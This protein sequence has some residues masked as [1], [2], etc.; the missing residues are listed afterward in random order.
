MFEPAWKKGAAGAARFDSQRVALGG[1]AS[2]L[3][4]V[5]ALRESVLAS[6][7]GSRKYIDTNICVKILRPAMLP[8]RT[9]QDGGA[10]TVP[11][12][13]IRVCALSR[14][15]PHVCHPVLLDKCIVA[16]MICAKIE[17]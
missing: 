2:C 13:G 15:S 1:S 8:W 7:T 9:G 17:K 3:A 14:G 12:P 16:D 11:W 6:C 10:L 4:L 5:T